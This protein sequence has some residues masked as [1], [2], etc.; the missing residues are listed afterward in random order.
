MLLSREPE[1]ALSKDSGCPAL[2]PPHPGPRQLRPAHRRA[3]TRLHMT[4]RLPNTSG[5]PNRVCVIPETL[6]AR[7]SPGCPQP[8]NLHPSAPSRGS[9]CHS[10]AL[11]PHPDSGY[12]QDPRMCPR[13][14]RLL[15]SGGPSILHL[16]C[17]LRCWSPH[18]HHWVS[19][20]G[21]PLRTPHPAWALKRRGPAP[22]AGRPESLD[23]HL[24]LTQ[25]EGTE[26]TGGEEGPKNPPPTPSCQPGLRGSWLSRGLAASTNPYHSPPRSHAP[27]NLGPPQRPA[28]PTS[29]SSPT[30]LLGGGCGVAGSHLG[31]RPLSLH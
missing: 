13:E 31:L 14:V 16:A 25:Q 6:Q 30:S 10:H 4:P 15:R 1:F 19:P 8:G 17:T 12:T 22:Q 18:S 24:V 20:G 21:G 5:S 7:Q 29:R 27:L 26:G 23:R 2:S 11:H 28:L 3:H 9:P